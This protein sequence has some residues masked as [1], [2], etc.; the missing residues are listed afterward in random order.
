MKMLEL[1]MEIDDS[2]RKFI[3]NLGKGVAAAGV[4]AAGFGGQIKKA[5][6]NDECF[7]SASAAAST[8]QENL[9]YTFGILGGYSGNTQR[10]VSPVASDLKN[11]IFQLV[12]K[13]CTNTKSYNIQELLSVAN[14]KAGKEAGSEQS[15]KWLLGRRSQNPIQ[16][17]VSYAQNYYNIYYGIVLQF[18]QQ[19]DSARQQQKQQRSS[20]SNYNTNSSFNKSS[21]GADDIKAAKAFGIIKAGLKFQPNDFNSDL[22]KQFGDLVASNAELKNIAIESYRTWVN[23]FQTRPELLDGFSR[24]LN[25]DFLLKH[26]KNLS[27]ESEDI[28]K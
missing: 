22:V 15:S 13:Y 3:S 16:D 23:R 20:N 7:Q 1:L 19:Y 12:L 8:A 14:T 4:A 9:M 10:Q 2:R 28:F 18:S 6:A 17:A 26:I 5:T 27:S 25:T 24:G 11:N 21:I